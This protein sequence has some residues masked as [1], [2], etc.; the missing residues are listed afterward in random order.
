MGY[1]RAM[2]TDEKELERI[3]L[4]VATEAG[5]LIL[6]G[7][8]KQFAVST[9]GP[10]A[11]LFTEY[12]VRS[13]ELVRERLTRQTP[14][15]PIVGEERG[16]DAGEDLTWYIDPID[17]TINFVA[18]HPYFA[19][20]LGLQRRGRPI[21]GA[22]VAPALR[23]TWSGTASG[24]TR[25]G[26]AISVSSTA[27]LSSA[28]IAT[29]FPSRS[30]ASQ[31]ERDLRLAQ[32]ARLLASARDIRRC[33]SAAIDLCM[34]ADGTYEA[35]WQRR[36]SPWDTTAGVAIILGAGGAW[37]VLYDGE[38]RAQELGTN[39][40]IDSALLTTLGE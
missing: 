6:E 5:A 14:E 18:G 26:E 34:V 4:Q 40:K 3:A 21:A 24:S 2:T 25:N 31:A 12:D 35:Y 37:R 23:L 17:G 29:G 39:S 32:Y 30:G 8:S 1:A 22:V 15:I 13:E 38:P 28:L 11:E 33:G 20:S 16:G 9:K 19:V 7:F 27:E 10:D 36:L